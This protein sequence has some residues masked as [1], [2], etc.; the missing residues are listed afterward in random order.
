MAKE[1]RKD[2][3]PVYLGHVEV[4][5]SRTLSKYFG[6]TSL[7]KLTFFNKGVSIEYT[8]ELTEEAVTRWARSLASER[9]PTVDEITIE[10]EATVD[11]LKESS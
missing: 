8:R 7:P 6:V 1:L 10:N 4:N 3:R 5:K 9:P 2:L 11:N